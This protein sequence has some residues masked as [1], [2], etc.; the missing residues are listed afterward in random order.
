MNKNGLI[1]PCNFIHK[2][3]PNLINGIQLIGFIL[4]A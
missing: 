4:P 1:V 2:I 3:V